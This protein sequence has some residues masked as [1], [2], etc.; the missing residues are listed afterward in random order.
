MT[1]GTRIKQARESLRMT[2]EQLAE[3]LDISRQAVSKWEA[4]LSRPAREKLEKL[5]AVLD[6]PPET[7]TEI[8]A[9]R[10]AAGQPPD[11]ARPWKIAAAVLAAGCAVL[12]AALAVTLSL[13]LPAPTHAVPAPSPAP[14]DP[15]AE[16]AEKALSAIFPG[17]LPLTVRHDFEFGD[18]PFGEY[19]RSEERRVGNECRL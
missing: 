8:D 17:T 4:D 3:E 6:I 19:D 13:L 1:Y 2:Q 7:W 16:D 14:E 5:S 18:Q 11:A 10:E 12:A 15:P 9:E